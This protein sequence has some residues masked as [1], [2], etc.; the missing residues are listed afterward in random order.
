MPLPRPALALGPLALLACAAC[1]R[2]V[3]RFYPDGVLRSTGR[4]LGPEKVP[5]GPWKT[6]YPGGEPREEG[7]FD[8]GRRVGV[9]TQWWP[10]GQRRSRG[11]RA[12]DETLRSSPREGAWTFWH[13]NGVRAAQGAYVKGQ[14]EG[15]W[16]VSLEDGTLDG[17]RT[18]E[19][20]LDQ[21]IG[22]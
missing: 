14:R 22:G 2:E 5:D 6:W 21:K 3:E 17:D 4:E 10:N 8:H 16:D 7:V 13:A 11:A 1:S 12:W 9:W 20:H 18:G 19:F 15:R